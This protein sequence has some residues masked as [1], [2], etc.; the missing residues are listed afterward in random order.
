[1]FYLLILLLKI[2]FRNNKQLIA[3]NIIIYNWF[4]SNILVYAISVLHISFQ[5]KQHKS[6]EVKLTC[7]MTFDTGVRM[8]C[9]QQD[10]CRKPGLTASVHH[11]K[12]CLSFFF[13]QNLIQFNETMKLLI[14]QNFTHFSSTEIYKENLNVTK[15]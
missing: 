1:M 11:F 7:E 14:Y 12:A 9:C 10:E 5:Y 3:S 8:I 2:M 4:E 6:S 15:P 13:L